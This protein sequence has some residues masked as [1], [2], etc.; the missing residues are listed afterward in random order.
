MLRHVGDDSSLCI[1]SE[2]SGGSPG[3]N[4]VVDVAIEAGGNARREETVVVD[5]GTG[6]YGFVQEASPD[7]AT[8]ISRKSRVAFGGGRL[9]FRVETD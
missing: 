8:Y 5:G 4:A 3:S 6:V 7:E 9:W 1:L 2:L